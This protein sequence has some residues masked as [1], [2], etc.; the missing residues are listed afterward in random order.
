MLKVCHVNFSDHLGGAAAAAYRLHTAL[1]QN[2]ADSVML[3]DFKTKNDDSVMALSDVFSRH[4]GKLIRFLN[5][6]PLIFYPRRQKNVVWDLARWSKNLTQ[7][8]NAVKADIV[9]L[10]WIN[11]GLLSVNDLAKI[12]KP[13][14]W[15]MH[16]EWPF[17][18]G[19]H[20]AGA[21]RLF[22]ADCGFCPILGSKKEFDPSRRVWLAKEKAWRSLNLT[23]I[24]PSRWLKNEAELSALFAQKPVILAA[25]CLPVDE[26]CPMDKNQARRQLG[27]AADKKIILAGAFDFLN[28]SRKGYELLKTALHSPSL[29]SLKE[30][31][32]VVFFG[33]DE[34]R[35]NHF[36]LSPLSSRSFGFIR[37]QQTMR[38]LYAAADIFVAPSLAENLANTIM[39]AM[40]CGTP[41]VA[42][43]SGGAPDLIEHRI[44]GYLARPFDVGDLAQGMFWLLQNAQ[45]KNIAQAARQ[46]INERFNPRSVAQSHMAVYRHIIDAGQNQG[47]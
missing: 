11:H 33:I 26:F 1:M 6:W 46:T 40:S 17:T 36:H 18:G 4:T 15:T 27:L 8:I 43:N 29:S 19:C 16:D 20:Y 30:K 2:G 44:N 37:E 3:V 5:F 42:F 45:T 39:E 14:V 32:Q 34:K 47:R 10:H 22:Q 9:H 23:L 7:K 31:I 38:Q 35:K 12:N 25:N 41:C 13:I 24:A 21:C 28:D